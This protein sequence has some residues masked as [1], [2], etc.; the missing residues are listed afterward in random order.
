MRPTS[1]GSPGRRKERIR[2]GLYDQL[3]IVI[4]L[5]TAAA[6]LISA[7]ATLIAVMRCEDRA[8]PVSYRSAPSM[9]GDYSTF[10]ARTIEVT[11]HLV[12]CLCNNLGA[13]SENAAE[14]ARGTHTE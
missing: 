5:A 4:A 1:R 10:G 3:K 13:A 12:R 7:M 14:P 11:R 6:T 9:P 8:A 2:W